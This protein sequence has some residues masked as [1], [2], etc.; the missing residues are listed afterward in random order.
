MKHTTPIRATVLMAMLA[1]LTVAGVAAAGRTA[2]ATTT[3]AADQVR[4]AERA[5][6]RASVDGDT[7]AARRLL[8]PDFQLID[9]LGESE[10]R[11][12]YLQTIGGGIDFVSI[13]PV[14]PMRVRLY[15]NTG[16]VRYRAMHELMAGPDRL[17]HSAW[18]TSLYER[19][20]GRWLLVW[21]QTTATPNDPALFVQALK[22]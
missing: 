8:A 7:G 5:L 1:L 21:S 3:A 17:K 11:A 22:S 10:T 4:E 6:L 2:G 20:Q 13:K 9:V 19:R 14:S 16:V 15:G 18:T 12:A